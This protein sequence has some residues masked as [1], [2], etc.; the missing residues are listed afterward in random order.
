M[1]GGTTSVTEQMRPVLICPGCATVVLPGTATGVCTGSVAAFCEQCVVVAKVG[2]G[3]IGP[4]ELL[5][6]TFL[7]DS[8]PV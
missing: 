4:P 6:T 8:E 2:G 7:T 1:G 5:I 3:V